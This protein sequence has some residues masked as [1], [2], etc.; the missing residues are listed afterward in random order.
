M[1]K[2]RPIDVS[3]N[4]RV[5][6]RD[7]NGNDVDVTRY[8]TPVTTDHT[9]L[10]PDAPS[11]STTK[12]KLY[13]TASSSTPVELTSKTTMIIELRRLH[14]MERG[15]ADGLEAVCAHC[16]YSWPCPTREIVDQV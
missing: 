9:W 8:F 16:G 1:A 15:F 10:D 6:L 12:V 7:A 3:A 5:T 11:T 14:V 4:A 2:M 13:T